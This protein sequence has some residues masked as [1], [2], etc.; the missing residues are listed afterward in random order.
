MQ[1]ISTAL[2]ELL[3]SLLALLP[4]LIIAILIFIASLYGAGLLS[5]MVRSALERR[6]TDR[7]IS[8]LMVHI[9]RWSVITLGTFTAL[10]QVGFNLTAFLTGLGI[11]GFTVGFALQDVSKNFVAGLLLLLEQPFD[12]GDVI[13]VGDYTGTVASVEIRATEIY[14]FDGQNVLIPNADV[15]TSP[16]KNF[17]RYSKRRL[18]HTIG[19]ASDS[20][21]EL[22]RVTTLEVIHG[23]PGIVMDP[24]PNLVFNNF[25]ES[26]IDFTVYY[27]VDL[28][29]GDYF[30]AIDTAITGI[31]TAFEKKGIEIPSPIR[32]V[33]LEDKRPT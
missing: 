9:T 7:E 23:I 15:F 24:A 10:L 14:T 6:K 11:L 3:A 22:V 20:D 30:K 21:L 4:D 8:I 25:G 28:K 33:V 26:S 17:S 32:T 29:I 16:I 19:V 1:P 2:D 13:E 5:R 31:K 18:D 12:L 27:W